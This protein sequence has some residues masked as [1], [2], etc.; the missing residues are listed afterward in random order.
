VGA[1]QISAA[2]VDAFPP[3]N[4]FLDLDSRPNKI[5]SNKKM[6]VIIAR[7]LGHKL[8]E[9]FLNSYKAFS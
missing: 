1:E 7:G 9:Q 8:Y 4:F 6:E 5:I 3:F 2:S